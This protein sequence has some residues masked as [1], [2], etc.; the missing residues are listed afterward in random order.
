[1]EKKIKVKAAIFDMD[2]TLVNS[3]MFWDSMAQDINNQFFKKENFKLDEEVDKTVR[4]MIFSK[5]MLYIR[6]FYDLPVTDEEFL[7]FAAQ[8]L[9]EFYKNQV[10][11]KAGIFDMLDF[12]VEKGVKLCLASATDLKYVKIA[13]ECCGLSKYFPIILS[14][15]D[16]GKGKDQPDIY[17]K[18]IEAL[19]VKLEDVCVFEDSPVALETA[20]SAGIT[21]IGVFDQYTPDQKRVKAA[22]DVYLEE[23][24]SM[25][26]LIPLFEC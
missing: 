17:Y 13:V 14:C 16:I 15:S 25:G 8:K 19:G 9:E 18:S 5:G 6:S 11:A 22:S 3:L 26:D 7:D 4:T 23:G 21:T 24:Q 20:Q 2:G 10:K 1:M 12:F